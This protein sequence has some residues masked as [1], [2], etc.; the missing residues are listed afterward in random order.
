MTPFFAIIFIWAFA[1]VSVLLL[2]W[3][4]WNRRRARLGKSESESESESGVTI[5][6][7]FR[8]E[9]QNLPACIA[10]LKKLDYPKELLEII[11]VND[12]SK[13][14]TIDLIQKVISSDS[15][16]KGINFSRNFGHQIAITAGLDNCK[17]D[18]A[19]VI[20]A[21]LQDPPCVILEM[22]KKWEE[23]YKIVVGVK[24]KSEENEDYDEDLEYYKQEI[25]QEPD[26]GIFKFTF[27]LFAKNSFPLFF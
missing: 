16:V 21:D 23:G 7:P 20:D 24:E 14:N 4:G 25:G 12:G 13:D 2:Y 19:V 10:S 26:S 17:G 22:V 6:V 1:Y 5:V 3:Q 15:R 9:A 27:F 18:A 11:F 8:N